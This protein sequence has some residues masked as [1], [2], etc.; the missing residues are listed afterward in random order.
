MC[1]GHSRIPNL[2]RSFIQSPCADV[3]LPEARH[4][5]LKDTQRHS[6]THC[7][8]QHLSLHDHAPTHPSMQSR[9]ICRSFNLQVPE[10][11]GTSSQTAGADQHSLQSFLTT[12][13]QLNSRKLRTF[14]QH[15]AQV[16]VCACVRQ[17]GCVCV[18]ARVCVCVCVCV[19]VCVCLQVC[20]CV[21]A[22]HDSVYSLSLSLSLAPTIHPPRCASTWCART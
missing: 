11:L 8:A 7:F 4:A 6:K 22:T 16:C 2:L 17:T 12:S 14:V 15:A 18:R 5:L 19:R 21:C 1:T 20:V 10:D 9:C 13:V 3:W